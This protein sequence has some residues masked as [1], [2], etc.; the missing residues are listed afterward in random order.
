[1]YHVEWSE[2][3][4]RQLER[5][6]NQVRRS[7]VRFMADRVHGSDNPRLIGKPLRQERL[8]RY[9]IGDYRV[10]CLIQD[11]VLVVLVVELGHRREVYR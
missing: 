2:R 5:L 11:D 6:D 10:L 3:S 7:I 9:R 8:W 1:M 4:V